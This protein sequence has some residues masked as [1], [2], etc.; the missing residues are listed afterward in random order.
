MVVSIN[1]PKKVIEELRKRGLSV[2]DAIINIVSKELNLDPEIVAEA[3]LELAERYLDE[4]KKLLDKDPIQASEKLYKAVEECVK[5][6]AKH[7]KLEDILGK[8]GERGRWTVT[9]L[10]KAVLRISERVGEW[11]RR[12]WDEANYLHVWGFHEAKLDS[13][14]V[15]ARA[16][17][18]EE[19]VAKAVALIRIKK[20][21]DIRNQ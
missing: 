7:F 3:H 2:E 17:D 10:E 15:K 6:F 5:A 14:D 1:I 13:E 18:V 12:V 4:G 11:F 19:A 21:K 20:E 9:D 8:V 16:R